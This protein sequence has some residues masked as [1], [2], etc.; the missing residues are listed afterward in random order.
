[1]K[2]TLLIIERIVIEALE[3]KSLYLQEIGEH[4][5]LSDGLLKAVLDGLIKQGIISYRK[6]LYELDW[7]NKENWLPQLQNKESM[8]VE[9]KEL[10][11][12]LVNNI[13]LNQG[14]GSLKVKKVWLEPLEQEELQR[15]LFEID[16][17]L[18]SIRNRRKLKP[19]KEVTKGKQVLFYGHSAYEELVDGLLKVS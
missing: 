12:S 4:T 8:K 5:G 2:K 1:M 9:I 3:G 10:F 17:F 19:V 14:K 6:G 7:S 18:E 16:Q 11:N 13:F 15:R